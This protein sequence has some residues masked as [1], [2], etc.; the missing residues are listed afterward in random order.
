MFDNH[1]I[2]LP[3]QPKT[4]L[5]T[6]TINLG[7]DLD[8]FISWSSTD[9][10]I[11]DYLSNKILDYSIDWISKTNTYKDFSGIL[12][13]INSI[14][15]TWNHE[16][17]ETK[18][19]MIIWVLNNDELLLS[20]IGKSSCYLVKK[21]NVIEVTDKKDIKKEFSFISNGSLQNNDI[22]IFSNKRLLNIFSESDFI[23]AFSKKAKKTNSSLEAILES[24][25]Y[26]KSISFVTFSYK[27]EIKGP[28]AA[29]SWFQLMFI[30]DLWLKVLDTSIAKKLI[31]LYMISQESFVKKWWL[32]KTILFGWIILLFIAILYMTVWRTIDET[33]KTD[34]IE[35]H[36]K[37][38]QKAKIA[39]N[40][41]GESLNNKD[42]FDLKIDSAKK[43]IANLREKELFASDLKLL[44]EE[45]AKIQKSS[46]GISSFD[47][48]E[49]SK[50]YTNGDIQAH[51]ILQIE[52]KTYAIGNQAISWPILEGQETKTYT[53]TALWDDVFIDA[54]NLGS[55]IVLLTKQWK[56]VNFSKDGNFKFADVLGQDSWEK[57]DQIASYGFN[58]MYLLSR[59]T[60][61]IYKHKKSGTN[62]TKW[63]PYIKK[64]DQQ[65]IW[66][67]YDVAIDGWF[68]I[69]KDNLEFLKFFS[70]NQ[71]RLDSL[72]INKLPNNYKIETW[73]ESPIIKT[74]QDLNYVY[75][76]LN[77]K[78]FIFEPNSKNFRLT[79]S[80]TYIGQI[81]WK[82][83]KILD[84]YVKY[85]GELLVLNS[86]WAYKMN[87]EVNEGKI[88]V[89]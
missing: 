57:A 74:R 88:L 19:N 6:R 34:N 65:N 40:S 78:I 87:F 36:Q 24:E 30:K 17:D 64:A 20:N 62:Y 43:I 48:N 72:V 59:E 49:E 52:K 15:N 54:T 10:R 50:I 81:E 35:A 38:L 29:S 12:E 23:D 76:L 3:L 41:A 1:N 28:A 89:K 2:S 69:L 11:L 70:W 39:V 18:I 86:A 63:T 9:E 7:N 25:K 13:Q 42:I 67:M 75:M 77:N 44:D 5:L 14:L 47:W 56:V 80:L 4:K 53:F 22:I 58:N 68:Y 32:F 45:I 84:F 55:T 21:N 85:D 60:N 61:Q 26:Q 82:S 8:L 73:S 31:A 37:E 66:K 16:W 79:K 33:V 83:N 51:T 27:K 71:Y 46:N